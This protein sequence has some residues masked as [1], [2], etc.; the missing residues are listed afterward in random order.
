MPLRV[1]QI[2]DAVGQSSAAHV[3]D[4]EKLVSVVTNMHKIPRGLGFKKIYIIVKI[5][6]KNV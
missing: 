5:A 1:H 3:M 4:F 2:W 6:L